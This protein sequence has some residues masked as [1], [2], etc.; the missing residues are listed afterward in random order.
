VSLNEYGLEVLVQERL[1]D[2]RA[3]AARRAL[4]AV[5]ARRRLRARLGAALIACGRWLVGEAE[6]PVPGTG[7]Q[8]VAAR[9]V[10]RPE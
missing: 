5:R 9:A 6:V 2:A 3:A 10:G 4:V 1:L 8:L 7:A